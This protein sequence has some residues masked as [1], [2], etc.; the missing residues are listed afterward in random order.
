[1]FALARTRHARTRHSALELTAVCRRSAWQ[2]LEA[3]VCQRISE[4]PDGQSQS[5]S[6]SQSLITAHSTPQRPPS[7]SR[8]S[9]PSSS[10]RRREAGSASRSPPAASRDISQEMQRRE[11]RTADRRTRTPERGKEGGRAKIPLDVSKALAA[12][13]A[14][15]AS[16]A[17]SGPPSSSRRPYR[18]GTLGGGGNS[19]A[20]MPSPRLNTP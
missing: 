2:V 5:Q 9:L 11:A 10:S 13:A 18:P 19:T 1:M 8:S 6:Q 7:R 20:G 16:A 17:A 15:A 12:S 4:L 3:A 14:S